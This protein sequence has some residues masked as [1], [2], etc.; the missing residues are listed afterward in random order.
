MHG[1]TGY[2]FY[3]SYIIK[4]L[5]L[6]L[7]FI[8]FKVAFNQYFLTYAGNLVT[9]K[10]IVG[11]GMKCDT[12]EP[13]YTKVGNTFLNSYTKSLNTFCKPLLILFAESSTPFRSLYVCLP[14]SRILNL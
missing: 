1:V 10:K 8:S 14:R 4:V 9:S 7:F 5:L 2:P 11:S 13:N 6:I 12:S 3:G